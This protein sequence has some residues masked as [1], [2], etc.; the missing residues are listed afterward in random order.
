M[1]LDSFLKLS[2]AFAIKTVLA[3]I[4]D[5]SWQNTGTNRERVE[6]IGFTVIDR[7]E[8]FGI[9]KVQLVTQVRDLL[10]PM[11][12]KITLAEIVNVLTDMLDSDEI[13]ISEIEET[14]FFH[15][16]FDDAKKYL[17]PRKF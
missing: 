4:N 13:S 7:H 16:N 9:Y 12:G 10:E 6:H 1:K 17:E 5:F 2:I 3:A 11:F 14:G 15:L 8:I